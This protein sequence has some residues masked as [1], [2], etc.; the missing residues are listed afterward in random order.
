MAPKAA[1]DGGGWPAI[2]PLNPMNPAREHADLA[3]AIRAHDHAY[4]VLARPVVS[5]FEYDRLYRRLVELET[6]HPE[7]ATPDSPSRRVGGAPIDGF[8]KVVH[9]VPMKS[10]EIGRAHV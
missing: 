7:L 10:L 4:Y 8:A 1:R 2:D 6:A 3:A 5:D 9:R